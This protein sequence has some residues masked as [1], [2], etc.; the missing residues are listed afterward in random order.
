MGGKRDVIWE[1]ARNPKWADANHQSISLEVKF[2]FMPSEMTF[3]CSPDDIERYS[4]DLFDRAYAGEFGKIEE[5]GL[6]PVT[7]AKQLELNFEEEERRLMKML[8]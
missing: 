3:T 5:F 7:I 4:Q 8:D 1:T 2:D 6:R